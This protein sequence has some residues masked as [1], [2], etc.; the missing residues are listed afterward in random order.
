MTDEPLRRGPPT[1]GRANWFSRGAG[2]LYASPALLLSLAALFW[3]GNA[4]AGQLAVGEVK[5]FLLVLLR[6]L[7]VTLM[8]WP[9]F[10]REALAHWSVIRPRLR[11]TV[12]TALAGFTLFNALLYLSLT[13]TTA[14]NVGILQGSMPVFVL[15]GAWFAYRAR[16]GLAALAGVA[17]TVVGVVIVASKGAVE[18]LLGLAFNQGDLLMLLA[19]VSYAGYIVALKQRP[20]MPGRAF[21]TL[22]APIAAVS[23]AP[24]AVIEGVVD[25]FAWPTAEGWLITAYVVVFPSCLAQLFFMRGVDLIGPGRAGVYINLLPVFAAILSVLILNERFERYHA[26]ALALVLFGIWLAQRPDPPTPPR[27]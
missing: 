18:V 16:I 24:L 11:W 17:I 20:E 3:A 15:I 27:P 22:M 2:A 23:A 1:V 12:M 21:F 19:C 8:L 4:V 13:R 10:G 6:W 5:P 26:L 9:L 7:F 25:G 14:L